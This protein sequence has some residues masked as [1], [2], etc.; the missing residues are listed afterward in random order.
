MAQMLVVM[1][2]ALVQAGGLRVRAGQSK[3]MLPGLKKGLALV[4]RFCGCCRR[5]CF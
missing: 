4:G 5:C 2:L 1:T 3:S